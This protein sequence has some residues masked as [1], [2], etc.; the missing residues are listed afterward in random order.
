MAV[1]NCDGFLSCL[2]IVSGSYLTSTM[3]MVA[4]VR[5]RW[6]FLFMWL[7]LIIYRIFFHVFKFLF[8]LETELLKS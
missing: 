7:N 3:C 4:N 2:F 8:A 6:H 5:R 1:L